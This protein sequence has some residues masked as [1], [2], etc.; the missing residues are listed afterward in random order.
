MPTLKTA[1]EALKEIAV[2]EVLPSPDEHESW[3]TKGISSNFVEAISD[4]KDISE[5]QSIYFGFDRTCQV[6][7]SYDEF[8]NLREFHTELVAPTG[9]E[10]ILTGKVV[11][12]TVTP[13]V[14][15]TIEGIFEG[16][17]RKMKIKISPEVY[18]WVSAEENR[19]ILKTGTL[20]HMPEV[21]VRGTLRR[22]LRGRFEMV[23]V[24]SIDIVSSNENRS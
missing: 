12:R 14:T 11:A 18:G 1:L 19:L 24:Q 4:L 7:L 17:S 13:D 20:D 8:S 21:K 3:A 22:R 6:E 10:V 9:K 23:E 16:Q 2:R 15:I 5:S